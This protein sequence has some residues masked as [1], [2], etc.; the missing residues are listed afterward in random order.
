MRALTVMIVAIAL[1]T[2]TALA[3]KNSSN[4]GYFYLTAG[5]D[6]D[7]DGDARLVASATFPTMAACTTAAAS[8][9]TLIQDCVPHCDDS[10]RT[11]YYVGQTTDSDSDDPTTFLYQTIG[12]YAS[13]SS[14]QAGIAAASAAGMTDVLPR[15]L[16]FTSPCK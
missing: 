2:G 10:E 4:G 13:R 14:C 8:E 7:S 1:A 9:T 15:C 11:V 5:M 12:P 6:T 3:G 16:T